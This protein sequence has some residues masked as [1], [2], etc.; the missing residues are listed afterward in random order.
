MKNL[1]VLTISL[2]LFTAGSL[3][4]AVAQAASERI[5]IFFDE[6]THPET[7]E[8]SYRVV[9]PNGNV[10]VTF[11]TTGARLTYTNAAGQVHSINV[12]GDYPGRPGP[13]ENVAENIQNNIMA[14]M[15]ESSGR[16][17]VVG[18]IRGSAQQVALTGGILL[19]KL[20]RRGKPGFVITDYGME[21]VTLVTPGEKVTL[22]RAI[23]RALKAES[24]RQTEIV[25]ANAAA[26]NALAETARPVKQVG[27]VTGAELDKMGKRKQIRTC[28]GLF[29][30]AK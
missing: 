20:E 9:N 3:S 13:V 27:F 17:F 18:T 2:L 5:A 6:S 14:D 12:I 8:L 7:G 28:E 22:A 4:F 21:D 11:T 24:N 1:K 29:A 26:A 30:I 19:L 23:F 10:D 16:Q 25:M 15:I